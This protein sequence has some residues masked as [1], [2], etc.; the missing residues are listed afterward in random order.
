MKITINLLLS[1]LIATAYT[2]CAMQEQQPPVIYLFAHGLADNHTQINRYTK[3]FTHKGT[4]HQNQ[5]HIL[6][7]NCPA[8]S[9]DFPDAQGFLAWLCRVNF[10]QTSMAQ[11]NEIAALKNKYDALV[12][13]FP[14]NSIVLIGLSR[15]ASVVFNFVALHKPT[16]V[17]LVILES[18][19]D[20]FPGVVSDI[21]ANYP[22]VQAIA[23]TLIDYGIPFFKY[24]S[25]GHHP[26]NLVRE[27]PHTIPVA[28]IASYEDTTVPITSTQRLATAL[29]ATGHPSMDACY[30]NHGK[31]SKIISGLD[32]GQYQQFIDNCYTLY[33]QSVQL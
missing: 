22:W 14:T 8:F 10:T 18:P 16:H 26:K 29:A 28:F 6:V 2:E 19:F 17:R 5:H 9:F 1:I 24:C 11:D 23:L 27:F 3:S 20:S 7:E 15:G 12:A 30:L 31:H 21:F 32:G 4:E 33:C 13:E 25:A